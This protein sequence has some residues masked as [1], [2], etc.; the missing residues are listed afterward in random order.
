M[1]TAF[2]DLGYDINNYPV[3]YDNYSREISLPIYPQ[4][5]TEKIKY[6]CENI[7]EAY[8]IVCNNRVINKN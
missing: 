4:L 2:K 3:S 6:I 7:A 8:T 5:N 1:L